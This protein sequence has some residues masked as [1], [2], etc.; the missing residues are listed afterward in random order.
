VEKLNVSATHIRSNGDGWGTFSVTTGPGGK[1]KRV[2]V[3]VK[4]GSLSVRHLT[5]TGAGSTRQKKSVQMG[6][7]DSFVFRITL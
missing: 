6:E 5:L 1:G 7:G 4:S 2:E 3:R